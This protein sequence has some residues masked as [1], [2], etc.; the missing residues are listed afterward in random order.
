MQMRDLIPWSRQSERG[1]GRDL[2]TGHTREAESHPFLTLHREMNRLF[3]D[4][5]RGFGTAD[6]GA[7]NWPSLE[8]AEDQKAIRISAELPGMDEHDVDVAYQDGA[9]TI[10]G[11]KRSDVEDKDRHYTE[12][13]YGRFER[14]VPVPVAIDEDAIDARFKKGVLTVTLPKSHTQRDG[15]RRIPI[16]KG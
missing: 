10:R 7:T 13:F 5:F 6:L 3:D 12:H 2:M 4:A 1:S 11:E 16:V 8:V 14:T 9:L 15:V